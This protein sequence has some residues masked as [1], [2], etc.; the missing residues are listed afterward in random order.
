M[1]PVPKFIEL[2]EGAVN[3]EIGTI[4]SD[5]GASREAAVEVFKERY[6]KKGIA[7]LN[8]VLRQKEMGD[9][10]ISL[11]VNEKRIDPVSGQEIRVTETPI[12]PQTYDG[13][14]SAI[15]EKA[16]RDRKTVYDCVD[17]CLWIFANADQSLKGQ[18]GAAH[19]AELLSRRVAGFHLS[20]GARHPRW[21]RDKIRDLSTSVHYPVAKPLFLRNLSSVQV[22]SLTYGALMGNVLLY[23]DWEAFAQL[24]Q[25]AGGEFRWGSKRDA[26]R[27]R[28]M[29][30]A[31]RP[32][33]IGGRIPQIHVDGAI[34]SITD[35]NLVEMFYDGVTPWSMAQ[36]TVQEMR[37]ASSR[38]SLKSS[39]L[40]TRVNALKGNIERLI[41]R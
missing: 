36:I 19:F 20:G 11:L 37:N 29:N 12:P 26:G 5:A 40:A 14:L 34:G 30:P 7:Q 15:L 3:E 4:L 22:A 25:K 35:P 33:L 21:D 17:G 28:A 31:I 2:K 13:S 10:A 32:P 38:A 39:P 41:G 9:Q 1:N 23:L 16:L 18:K 6:G 24:I 8:R 27:A